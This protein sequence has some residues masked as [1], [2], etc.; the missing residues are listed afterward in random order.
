MKRSA[1]LLAAMIAACAV[2]AAAATTAAPA[3]SA[4]ASDR[5]FTIQD[6]VFLLDG[7]PFQII[8]GSMHYFRIHPAYWEDRLQRARAMGIN[9]I[10]AYVPWNWHEPYP[11]QYEWQGWADVERW[12]QLIQDSGL[13]VVLRP[14]P[15]IC[16]EWDFGGFPWWLASSKVAGGRSMRLRTSDPSYLAHVDRWWAALFPRMRRFLVQ[17]GGPILMVQ[18][19]N[20]YGFCGEDKEY[21]RHL[22]ATARRH[23]SEEVLLFTTDPP[24]IASK[25]SIKGG[26]VYTVVDFGPAW[27]N[28]ADAFKVQRSLNEEGQS[29]PF[30]SEFY[31]GWLTHWGETMANTSTEVLVKD[32]QTLLEFANSTGSLSFYMIHGGTNFGFWAGAGLDGDKYAAH[33]TSYDYDCPISEA[34]DYCQPGIGGPCKYHAL[35]DLLAR[36]T[37][38]EPPEPPPRPALARYGRV[39]LRGPV[40]LLSALAELTG[41]GGG[42]RS[43]EPDIM[44][45]YGQSG[46]LILYRTQLPPGSL[47]REATLD[48]GAPVHDYA[49]VLVGGR[50]AGRLDRS[51]PGGT[52][53]RLPAQRREGSSGGGVD[54]LQLDILV[55][56]MGRA[57]FGCDTG[58]WD[59]KGLT[60][61]NVT[62]D[63]R[64]LRGWEVFPLPLDDVSGH[65]LPIPGMP[66]APSGGGTAGADAGTGDGVLAAA[67]RRL[68]GL[69]SLVVG[70]GPGTAASASGP[71][72]YSGTFSVDGTL[73]RGGGGGAHPADT[74]LSTKGWGKG[75]AWVNGFNLGWY[76]PSRG[77]QMTLYVPGPVLREGRN[78]LVLLELEAPPDKAAVELTDQPDFW[79]PGG[80]AAAA[81][82]QQASVGDG[83]DPFSS[84]A[85]N[86]ELERRTG[87]LS[88]L[89]EHLDLLLSASE[90]SSSSVQK[91][92]C[93]RGTGEQE[94]NWCHGTVGDVLYCSE[95]GCA[96]CPVCRGTGQCKCPNCC[97]TGKRAS[98]LA[99]GPQ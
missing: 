13:K 54:S 97:G 15:Y 55:E 16:A 82:G 74:Y 43:D 56:A 17:N 44:E 7:E 3:V 77:P 51:Q 45:E 27:F 5:N 14:G 98:W 38:V 46:G 19:E 83:E 9:T 20:E 33:I 66:A 8:S 32:T 25:G 76:W 73:A 88:K 31:T 37:G 68:L 12:M 70:T 6:D 35:R 86:R 93:C 48:L 63:G 42:I 30:C 87:K 81:S 47:D 34:G 50:L 60:S 26:E 62:L 18:V 40:P 36:H 59:F 24:N 49:S 84:S 2:V 39:K 94:C 61:K 52:T 67:R 75:I 72:F 96:P 57:N 85:L 95:G 11:G 69:P 90:A 58:G 21:L 92:E 4:S 1:A 91:C 23:L 65:A 99:K 22:I 89:A 71:A 79:G 41:G 53:L 64:P 29:P 80:A 28:P 78:D 10:E